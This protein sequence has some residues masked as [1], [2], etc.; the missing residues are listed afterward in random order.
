MYCSSCGNN[1]DDDASFCSNCGRDLHGVRPLAPA[2]ASPVTL[3]ADIPNYL[4]LAIL[5]TIFCCLPF[6]IVSIVYAAQVN[7]KRAVGDIGGAIQAS[8]KAK[9]WIWVSIGTGL[10]VSLI[11]VIVSLFAPSDT[12]TSTIST[13]AEPSTTPIPTQSTADSIPANPT[14]VPTRG[15]LGISRQSVQSIFSDPDLG[16]AFDP[17]DVLRDGRPRVLGE[18]ELG[19]AIIE[20]IGPPKDLSQATIIVGLPN[21]NPESLLL[22]TLYLL[23]FVNV[24]APGWSDGVDWVTA[25]IDRVAERGE[26]ETRHGNLLIKF[27]LIEGLGMLSLSIETAR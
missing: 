17:P 2:N 24:V 19:A 12:P 25:N 22:S 20:L 6:G 15:G 7:R 16:F 27:S 21:D 18:S 8:K 9:I 11:I 14:P 10:F 5:V 13:I 26:V 1:T 23:G 4:V 3:P